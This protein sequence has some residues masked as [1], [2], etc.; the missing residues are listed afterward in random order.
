MSASKFLTL[1]IY[2]S[3]SAYLQTS[4]RHLGSYSEKTELLLPPPLPFLLQIAPPVSLLVSQLSVEC[5]PSISKALGS[6]PALSEMGHMLLYFLVPGESKS[7][8]GTLAVLPLLSLSISFLA[9][10]ST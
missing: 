2:S 1:Y 7:E 3:R 4:L 5:L 8:Y 9:L 6:A 10:S